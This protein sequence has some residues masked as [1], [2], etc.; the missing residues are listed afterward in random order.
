[1]PVAPVARQ[2]IPCVA[3]KIARELCALCAKR[4]REEKK[5]EGEEAGSKAEDEAK[6]LAL[7]GI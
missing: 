5:E 4:K 7:I 3:I 1:M 6:S 2:R